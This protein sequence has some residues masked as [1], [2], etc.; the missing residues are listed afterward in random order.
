MKRPIKKKAMKKPVK[1]PVSKKP[2]VKTLSDFLDSEI[3]AEALKRLE[4]SKEKLQADLSEKRTYAEEFDE[5]FEALE[6]V[7][8]SSLSY[9][10]NSPYDLQ[11]DL[12]GRIEDAKEDLE[13]ENLEDEYRNMEKLVSE[14]KMINFI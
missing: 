3:H 7:S 8:T 1:K 4:K 5:L 14:F 2:K 11:N 9:E 12:K 13:L 6:S 10:G